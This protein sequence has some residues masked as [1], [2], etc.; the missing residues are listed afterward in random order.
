MSLMRNHQQLCQPVECTFCG[1][2]FGTVGGVWDAA[3]GERVFCCPPC[4]IAVLPKLIADSLHIPHQH[5][6]KSVIPAILASY[7]EAVAS[8]N[9]K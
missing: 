2:E 8:R 5:A 4:A 3:A 7:W 1:T 9:S 6:A